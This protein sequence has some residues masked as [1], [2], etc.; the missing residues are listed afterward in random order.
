MYIPF[1]CV[2]FSW[3]ALTSVMLQPWQLIAVAI[4]EAG[5]TLITIT[6]IKMPQFAHQSLKDSTLKENEIKSN[7]NEEKNKDDKEM[8]MIKTEKKK[9]NEKE[10]VEETK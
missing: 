7:F 1:L 9:R 8:L 5:D 10:E 6:R 4:D 3:R 2:A